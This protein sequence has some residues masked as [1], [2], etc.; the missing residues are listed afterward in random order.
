MSDVTEQAK[1]PASQDK[2]MAVTLLFVAIVCIN[3]KL[4]LALPLG[5]LILIGTS[6]GVW[7]SQSKL[8]EVAKLKA[9]IDGKADDAK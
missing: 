6:L 8:A 2:H 1:T 9:L 7:V 3:H 4:D 5:E